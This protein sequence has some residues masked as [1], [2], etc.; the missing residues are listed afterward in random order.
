MMSKLQQITEN[1]GLEAIIHGGSDRVT[2]YKHEFSPIYT[3]AFFKANE[4]M[5]AYK[6]NEC[7][8]GDLEATMRAYK[9]DLRKWHKVQMEQE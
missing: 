6:Y 2:V 3:F 9:S 7:L 8:E 5:P 1:D 4:D